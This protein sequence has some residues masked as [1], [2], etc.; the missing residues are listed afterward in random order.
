M[1][2]IAA[3]VV[4][5]L[6]VVVAAAAIVAV[7]VPD[8]EFQ[9]LDVADAVSASVAG[10]FH[11]EGIARRAV[12]EQGD[13][14]KTRQFVQVV[15]SSQVHAIGAEVLTGQ[16]HSGDCHEVLPCMRS[17]ESQAFPARLSRRPLSSLQ[18]RFASRFA[19][20]RREGMKKDARSK[21]FYFRGE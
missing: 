19:V 7:G 2:A 1:V 16:V 14:H 11:R 12:V 5:V 9:E 3:A 17:K 8:Q 4:M 21:A 20:R 18:R 10:L 13:H 15:R 6:A